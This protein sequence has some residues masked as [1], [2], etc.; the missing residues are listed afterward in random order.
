MSWSGCTRTNRNGSPLGRV[1]DRDETDTT[2]DLTPGRLDYQC[3]PVLAGRRG[4]EPGF[5]AAGD[6]AVVEHPA[7]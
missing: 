6:L 3:C 2:H 5:L 1:A 4:R 7:A